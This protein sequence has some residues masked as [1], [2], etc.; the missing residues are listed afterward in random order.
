[1]SK[2]V[3]ALQQSRYENR[4]QSWFHAMHCV[5]TLFALFG[6][7]TAPRS[8]TAHIPPDLR[9]GAVLHVGAQPDVPD[10]TVYTFAFYIW[11]QINRWKT[12]GAKDYGEQIYQLQAFITPACREQLVADLNQRNDAGELARRTRAVMEIPGLGY[13][14][15][16]VKVLGG[17][18]W[19]VLLDTQVQETQANMTVKDAYIR[20]PMRIVRFDVDRERNPW[21]LAIDC[22]DGERPARLDAKAVAVAQSGHA[23]TEL[24]SEPISQ[25]MPA[26]R[27]EGSAAGE[28]GSQAGTPTNTPAGKPESP[29]AAGPVAT[30]PSPS[31]A[32]TTLPR[33]LN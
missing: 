4:R 14:A 12:D 23:I 18:A 21:Q 10:T 11:Q 2:F 19:K 30:S 15:E 22:F 33:A 5:I 6:W 1:M 16:R 31:I 8:I 13:T 20:Y 32:P 25:V 17:S 28:A 3:D 7:W 24:R 27:L 26:A 29:P 9:N